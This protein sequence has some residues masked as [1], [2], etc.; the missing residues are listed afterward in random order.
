MESG[1]ITYESRFWIVLEQFV[2]GRHGKGP[3]DYA[4]RMESGG[5]VESRR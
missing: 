5:V 4:I 3:M 1:F 2:V